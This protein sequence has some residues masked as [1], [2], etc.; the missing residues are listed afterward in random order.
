MIDLIKDNELVHDKVA[1]KYDWRHIEIY[2]EVEQNRIG[3]VIDSI[4]KKFHKEKSSLKVLDYWAWTWNLTKFFLKNNCKVTS[5]D[6]SEESLSLLQKSYSSYGN[7]EIQK[8]EG[9]EIPFEDWSFDIVA[10]YSVLHHIPDYIKALEDITRV[11]NKGWILYIDHEHNKNHWNAWPELIAYTNSY[12]SFSNKLKTIISS[13]E[14]LEFNFWKGVFI[15][16]FIN[17]K[18]A[19]E[20]DI[21]VWKDDYIEWESIITYLTDH[22]FEIIADIDYLWYHPYISIEDYNL[23]KEKVNNMKYLIARKK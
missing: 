18:Y 11:I 10:T 14:I 20:W 17:P 12:N 13:G 19:N 22:G 6:I 3:S 5:L 21:H 4:L 7:L 8:F 15:R 9:Y 2:N 16:Q 1:K 23:S